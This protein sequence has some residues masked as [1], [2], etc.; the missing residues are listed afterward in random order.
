MIQYN[1]RDSVHPDRHPVNPSGGRCH[2]CAFTNL[3][4]TVLDHYYHFVA[5]L[6]LGT[7]AFWNG[8]F[9]ATID[10]K[11]WTSDAPPVRRAIFANNPPEG[12]RD[13]PGFNAYFLRSA[14]SSL[15]V[16][17]E[18]DW[19]DRIFMTVDGDRAY[20]F[21]TVLIADRS[22]AFK[23]KLCGVPT[24]GSPRRL[25]NPYGT[26]VGSRRSGGNPSGGRSCDSL[27][28]RRK[29]WVWALRSRGWE[30]EREKAVKALGGQPER[31]ICP[32]SYRQGEDGHHVHQ[33]ASNPEASDRE[34]HQLL[35][36]SLQ[37]MT[38]RKGYEL[39]IIEAEKLSKDEQLRIMSRTTVR[40][41]LHAHS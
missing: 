8:A 15:T 29:P 22:A 16:E 39:I 38:A 4:Y 11:T 30:G 13:K 2:P 32:D 21:D 5:E 6:L 40:R 19:A 34:D 1:V 37:E 26:A 17:S 10:T 18:R 28:S 20:H 36:A 3:P 41:H 33:Q 35:V 27:V 24:S 25:T 31:F 14:F 12:F 23:G 7:W 9:N